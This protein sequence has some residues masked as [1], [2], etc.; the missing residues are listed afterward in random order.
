MEKIFRR[1]QGLPTCINNFLLIVSY[2]VF[3]FVYAPI[4]DYYYKKWSKTEEFGVAF[5]SHRVSRGIPPLPADWFT[6]D[7][8]YRRTGRNRA[9]YTTLRQKWFPRDRENVKYGHILKQIDKD[10]RGITE[11]LDKFLCCENGEYLLETF[12]DHRKTRGI[13]ATLYDYKNGEATNPRLLNFQQIDSIK[14]AW[15]IDWHGW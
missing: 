7:T 5:N 2:L 4:T 1:G 12:F 9:P 14:S 15:D 6:R 11:E 3:H 13:I 10:M 8:R